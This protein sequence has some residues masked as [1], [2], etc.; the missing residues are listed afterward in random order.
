M[1]NINEYVHMNVCLI[2]CRK[3]KKEKYVHKKDKGK[4]MM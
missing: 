3:K 4:L 2:M 1:V